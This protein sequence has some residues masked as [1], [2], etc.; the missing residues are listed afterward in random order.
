MQTILI[1]L[2]ITTLLFILITYVYAMEQR[3]LSVEAVKGEPEATRVDRAIDGF[4]N[5][6]TRSVNSFTRFLLS[7]A[8]G[9]TTPGVSKT[10]QTLRYRLPMAVRPTGGS[11]SFCLATDRNKAVKQRK[12]TPDC[13]PAVRGN[14]SN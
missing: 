8:R 13:R 14:N 12:K 1:T 10:D 7:T 5:R 4:T 6:W 2:M 11:F 3:F 9:K